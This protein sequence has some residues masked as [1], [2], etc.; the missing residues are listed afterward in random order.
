MGRFAREGVW[1]VLR[2]FGVT[3]AARAAS[4]DP[5]EEVILLQT[6]DIERVNVD[7]LTAELMGVLPH[8]KV[9]V[10]PDHPRWASEPL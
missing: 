8:T 1:A 5:T 4:T 10:A 2:R 7:Q 6:A 9:W 3:S